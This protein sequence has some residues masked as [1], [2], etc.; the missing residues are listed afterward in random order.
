MRERCKMN[1]LGKLLLYQ[2]THPEDKS[3]Q[4]MIRVIL[5]NLFKIKSITIDNLADMCYTSPS[6][7]IRLCKKLGYKNFSGFR[8]EIQNILN[9]YELS[10]QPIYIETSAST[11]QIRQ[12]LVDIIACHMNFFQ[13]LDDQLI[14][15][16]AR[17]IHAKKECYFF[18]NYPSPMSVLNL[19]QNL[20]MDGKRTGYYFGEQIDE[21]IRRLTAD[22]AAFIEATYLPR[23]VP[24]LREFEQIKQTNASTILFV[25]KD[26]GCWKNPDI[27]ICVEGSGSRLDSH[28]ADY[29]YILLSCVYRNKYISQ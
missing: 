4:Q 23:E 25:Y 29:F 2:N 21:G 22:S 24:M 7:V 20:I 13:Q 10:N 16:A 12:S 11:C 17:L 14:E 27:K 15:Q 5:E 18:S 8:A 3:G 19:Q 28:I 6:S 9:T 26:L 1:V